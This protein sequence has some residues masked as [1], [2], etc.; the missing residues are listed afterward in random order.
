MAIPH[1]NS[2]AGTPNQPFAPTKSSSD[3]SSLYILASLE[4]PRNKGA[5]KAGKLLMQLRKG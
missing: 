3:Q 1:Q 5:A 2:D 4:I